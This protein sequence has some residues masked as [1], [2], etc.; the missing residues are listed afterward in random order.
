VEV[1]SLYRKMLRAG[2]SF[3]DYNFREYAMNY[4]REEFRKQADLKD[5]D[6]VEGAVDYGFQQL[7][8]LQ[9]QATLGEMYEWKPVV[10]EQMPIPRVAK[11]IDKPNNN[12]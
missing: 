1:L 10:V 8:L 3:K 7:K 6:T 5:S 4:I 11:R 9:R 2:G 12:L